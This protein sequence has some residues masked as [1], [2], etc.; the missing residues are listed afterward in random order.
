VLDEDEED[1]ARPEE[2]RGEPFVAPIP[3]RS[4]TLGWGGALAGGYIFRIDPED[5]DSPPFSLWHIGNEA[6]S[7]APCDSSKP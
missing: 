6:S 3:F 1:D 5:R 4:P 7:L 2:K